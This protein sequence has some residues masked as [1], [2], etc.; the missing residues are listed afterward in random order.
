MSTN[1][2]VLIVDD[3]SVVRQALRSGLDKIPG[4][5]V[6]GLA[7]DPYV[8][9]DQIIKLKPDVLTLDLEMPRMDGLTFLRKLMKFHP[10]P[11]IIF[12]SVTPE[13]CDTAI[14]CLEAGA[15]DVVCKPGEA[16]SV[17]DATARLG[18]LIL[19]AAKAGVG[20]VKKTAGAPTSR[21]PATG[22]VMI[23]TTRKVIALG[24]STGGTEALRQVLTQLPRQVPGI[25][26]TQ[27]MPGGF[28]TS[29]AAR[30][31][32][33]CEIEVREAVD[34][35]AVVPGLALLAPGDLHMRLARDG[36][37][38][39]VKVG[40]GPRVCRH[41][42]SVEVLFESTAKY[43]GRNAMGVI[44][45]GMGYDGAQGLLSMRKAGA[46]TVAQDEASCV[47]FG[48]PGAAIERDA[49]AIV[50]PLAKIPHHIMDFATG[51][52]KATA[53]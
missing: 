7:P 11:T 24:T 50:S 16:Y 13:G 18:E 44:M 22:K 51:K 35:D 23:E 53:A 8:A 33:L 29:F 41:R 45:T 21:L 43:A 48:M 20:A 30:L 9:R 19:A 40:S 10:L 1:A 25:I 31:N 49:A 42:P 27:H 26:M 3:S 14:A 15:I 5:E 2:R 32:S 12:S 47:V 38:Y 34:G 39:I 6:V 28:T 46:V 17:G 52:L 36:A 37:R 4:I